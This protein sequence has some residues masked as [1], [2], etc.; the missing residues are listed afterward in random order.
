MWMLDVFCC[1]L[2]CVTL[3]LLLNSRMA[4]DEAAANKT[5]LIDLEPRRARDLTLALTDARI[6]LKLAARTPR[7][8]QLT[9]RNSRA[10][11]TEK[12]DLARKLGIARDEAKSAQ[13]LL[14][15]TKVALNAA[16]TKV[17]ATAKELA[18]AREKAATPTTL[19]RKK[20]K[21]ADTLAKKLTD[22]DRPRPTT[23][24]GCS[25]RRTTSGSCW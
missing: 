18:A 17:D 9:T 16:E 3:L 5:A 23:S 13:A 4:G 7:V 1:A 10:I 15:A 25:A 22:D 19:L 21:D 20:Q 24:R 14:D 6:G 2:G 11:R 12:D 8:Q